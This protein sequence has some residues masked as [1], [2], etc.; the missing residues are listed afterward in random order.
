MCCVSYYTKPTLT[1]TGQ[2]SD[3]VFEYILE[4]GVDPECDMSHGTCTVPNLHSCTL[5]RGILSVYIIKFD[6]SL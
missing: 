5:G 3:V 4:S 1:Q 2:I 6:P